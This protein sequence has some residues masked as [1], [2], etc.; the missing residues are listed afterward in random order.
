MLA[1]SCLLSPRTLAE[2]KW[3]RT[4]NTHGRPGTNVPIDLHMEHLNKRLKG[5]MCGLGSYITP[6]SIQR[7]SKALGVIEAVC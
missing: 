5:I 2:L 4:I 6:Q 1:P 3:S 7:A